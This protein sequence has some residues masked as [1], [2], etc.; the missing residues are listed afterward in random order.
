MGL[1]TV[2]DLLQHY[3]RRGYDRTRQRVD[4]ADL[5]V[6]EQAT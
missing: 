4:I 3:P 2:L 6:G 5:Q 1:L